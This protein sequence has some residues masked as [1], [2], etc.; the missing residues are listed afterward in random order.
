MFQRAIDI[1]AW[2][3]LDEQGIL[4]DNLVTFLWRNIIADESKRHSTVGIT[5]SYVLCRFMKKIYSTEIE[6][7]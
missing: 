2:I 6:G 7:G 4:E 5:L 1:D 3:K